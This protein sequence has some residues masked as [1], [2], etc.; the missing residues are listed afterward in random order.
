MSGRNNQG[1]SNTEVIGPTGLF[2][3]P[4]QPREVEWSTRRITSTRDMVSKIQLK[5]DDSFF[6]KH[7]KKIVCSMII[8]MFV[9]PRSRLGRGGKK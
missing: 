3:P 2:S 1:Y 7:K 8:M 9:V 4:Y 5:I 6:S